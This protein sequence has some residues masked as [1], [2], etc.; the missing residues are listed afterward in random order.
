MRLETERLI[1]TDFTI[2]MAYD[3]HINSLDEDNRRFVPDEV[4]ETTDDAKETI[5]FLIT[6]Y[7]TTEGPFVHPIITKD[8]KKNIGYVQ[9]VPIEDEYEIGYHIAKAYTGNG[10][11]TEAAKAFLPYMA[12]K[13][14]LKEIWGI[15]L[16]EN[17]ASVKVMEKCGFQPVFSGTGDYQ[18]EKRKIRKNIWKR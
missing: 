6:R 18:G 15:C 10:Y 17:T 7:G 14:D 2:D 13:F 16:A 3:V 9:L 11:A 4:F 1:I 12:D 5:E 8:S